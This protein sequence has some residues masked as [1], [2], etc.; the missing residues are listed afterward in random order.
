M[1]LSDAAT[2]RT[3]AARLATIVSKYNSAMKSMVDFEKPL[4]DR[5]LAKIDHVSQILLFTSAII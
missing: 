3:T 4:F 1:V 5:K 2:L